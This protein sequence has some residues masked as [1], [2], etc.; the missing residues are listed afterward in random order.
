MKTPQENWLSFVVW[1]KRPTEA[2]TNA[3]KT[4]QIDEEL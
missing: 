4:G 3:Y 2:F 1:A